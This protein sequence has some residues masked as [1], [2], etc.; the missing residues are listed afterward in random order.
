MKCTIYQAPTGNPL[1]DAYLFQFQSVSN[2]YDDQNPTDPTTFQRRA[3]K[4]L[5]W[6]DD[7]H[8]QQLVKALSAYHERIGAT[9]AQM[10]GI[11]RLL[12]PESVVV[13][14]GQQAGLLTGPLY[15]L[16]KALSAIGVAAE[17][18]RLLGRPV[19]PVFWVASEDHDFAEVDHAYVIDHVNVPARIELDHSFDPHQM[20]YHASLSRSQVDHVIQQ[21][22]RTL[23]ETPYK[24]DLLHTL[25]DTWRE[26]DSLAVW[27][28][29]L[30]SRMLANHP[31]V[32]V[33]PCLPELR[34]LVA[35][36]FERTLANADEVQ[37]RLSDAYAAV[38]AAGFAP[39]VIRDDRHTTV[40]R[41]VD[42]RRYVIERTEDGQLRL[43]S[44]GETR[45]LADWLQ[46]CRDD[47]AGFS[48]NVLL[49]PVVQDHLLPTL[50]YVGGPSELAYHSLSKAI[51]HAH[52][53][54]LPPLVMRQRMR[55]ASPGVW[56]AMNAWGIGFADVRQPA[57]L[58]ALRALRDM[59]ET[60]QADMDEFSGML[61]QHM[62]RFTA[63]YEHLG[64]QVQDI[65][66]RHQTQQR[67]LLERLHR[68]VYQLAER[69]RHDDVQQL[70]RIETWFWTDGHEQ[71][72]RLSPMNLWAEL[73]LE[74]FHQ[75]P[76]W[77]DFR[78]PGAVLELVAE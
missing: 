60:L 59:T 20:V 23:H 77:G 61:Q 19:V 34:R 67:Q 50:A 44:H 8:R 39:E 45:T 48:S 43:R 56:R 3:E 47:P 10:N 40:F 29:R 74:W 4:V 65:V 18:E 31:I 42:G 41:V 26:G 54:S 66:A 27:Y 38:E 14:T 25:K 33:D 13:V 32:F 21:V 63:T 72:R 55:I 12:D 37:A 64:P 53:R 24:V 46:L 52:G 76:V 71:E 9:P 22:Q 28:T 68:K 69:R 11:Q 51:F 17:M 5:P 57:D 49:R 16:S 58:V 6:F 30:M 7:T 73:S 15:S 35:P 36:V 2:L 75:L 78:Q 70:R 1:T 62:K